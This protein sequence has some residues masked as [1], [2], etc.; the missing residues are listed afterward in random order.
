MT[1]IQKFTSSRLGQTTLLST[2]VKMGHEIIS[3]AIFALPLVQLQAGQLSVTGERMCTS[4][5]LLTV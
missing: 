5:W 1:V 4:W 2:F 3:S